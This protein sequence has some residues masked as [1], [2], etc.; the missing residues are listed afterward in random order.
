MGVI[1][2]FQKAKE[3]FIK[4]E[5]MQESNEVLNKITSIV[6]ELAP[7]FNKLNGGDLSEYQLKLSGYKFYLADHVSELMAKSEYLKAHIKDQKAH[8]WMQIVEE[9]KEAEGKVRNKEQV[10]NALIIQLESVINEQIFYEAEY[11]KVRFKSMAVD[12]ILTAICQRVAELKR[13]IDQ[14]NNT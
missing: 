10:E 7:N 13:Q 4:R 5:D 9:I 14:S 11:Q 3:D 8:L 6:N 1:E 12:N 2:Q